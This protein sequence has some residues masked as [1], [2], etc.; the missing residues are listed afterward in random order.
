[1]TTSAFW[2]GF[3][4]AFGSRASFDFWL[5]FGAALI[6]WS[7]ARGMHGFATACLSSTLLWFW[8]SW[9]RT[10]RFET[11]YF[12]DKPAKEENGSDALLAAYMYGF[13]RG[14]DK[15]ANSAPGKEPQ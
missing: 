10:I 6:G 13:E 14:L 11:N 5:V 8:L 4:A 15:G 9:S 3:F 7:L 2:R 12:V 1:M